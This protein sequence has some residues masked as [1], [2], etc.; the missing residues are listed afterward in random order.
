MC[1]HNPDDKYFDEAR[2]LLID[3]DELAPWLPVLAQR[4]QCAPAVLAAMKRPHRTD[5]TAEQE[6]V[7]LVAFL[8]DEMVRVIF[9]PPRRAKMA[10]QLLDVKAALADAQERDA[11]AFVYAALS[12]PSLTM[13]SHTLCFL[14]AVCIKSI[15]AIA[16]RGM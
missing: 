2:P 1:L 5:K 11:V 4:L 6:A 10:R 16:T 12:A 8:G 14:R 9:T 7:D 15:E 13:D 3:A